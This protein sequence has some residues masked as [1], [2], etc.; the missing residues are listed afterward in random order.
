MLKSMK[1]NPKRMVRGYGR[2]RRSSSR[3]ASI[4][5]G[6]GSR[7]CPPRPGGDRRPRVPGRPPGR[8]RRAATDRAADDRRDRAA[9]T[10]ARAAVGR[11][12]TCCTDDPDE[13]AGHTY[14]KSFRDVWRGLH[15]DFSRPPDLVAIPRDEHD[16]VALLDW[17]SDAGSR[18][19]PTA[20]ARRWSAASSATSTT[21]YR[22][23]VSIDLRAL[24]QVLEIDRDSR[25]ARIQAGV[26]GPA[27]EDQLRPHGLTLRHFP[28]S[29]EFSTLGGWLATR[30]GGHYA[31]LH[32][33]I[34]DFVES[35]RAVTP[36]GRVGEPPPARLR[37]RP[38]ARPA[39]A[40]LGGHA[41]HHHRGVD[42]APGPADVPRVGHRV[43]S[44]RSTAGLDA[45]RVLAQ[46]G[47]YPANCRL[48]DATEAHAHR[49]RRRRA[50]RS[51]SSRSSRPTIPLDAWIAPRGRAACV[52]L[53]RRHAVDDSTR[54]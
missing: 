31:T 17:C 21:T 7:G 5:L 27:L 19:S 26:F 43:G 34:D 46:S 6:L 8:C 41:R 11:S 53:R 28:Q 42:A 33:H 36:R 44:R 32:T 29:F 12:R 35:I 14:G 51:C 15:R 1:W 39:V 24:D 54:S 52:D 45:A 47:L 23:A 22:G 2:P 10:A 25:A 50:T 20:A 4:V 3:H 30:S 9:G 48:L 38:V 16:I 13:R 49:R 40:R 18:P 37:R